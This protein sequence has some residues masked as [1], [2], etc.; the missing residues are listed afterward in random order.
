MKNNLREIRRFN[1]CDQQK[2]AD[3]INV[4]VNEVQLIES[5]VQSVRFEVAY[6][7]SN[8]LNTPIDK[9]FPEIKKA[10]TKKNQKWDLEVYGD[11]KLSDKLEKLGFDMDTSFNEVEMLLRGDHLI[12]HKLS[13]K[14][15]KHLWRLVQKDTHHCDFVVYDTKTHR[16]ALNLKHLI[17]SHFKF[18]V[19]YDYHD[20]GLENY[21]TQVIFAGHKTVLELKVD[22]DVEWN[23]CDPPEWPDSQLGDLFYHAELA[24]DETDHVFMIQ[25]MEGETAFLPLKDVAMASVPLCLVEPKLLDA[26]EA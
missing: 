17:Y 24:I 10:S 6:R 1:D 21:K 18:E 4:N 15:K 2:L 9:I 25:D 19:N 20:D 26:Q 22:P 12:T 11:H 13:S 16:V 5:E 3:A 23:D 14:E 7:I 8:Y